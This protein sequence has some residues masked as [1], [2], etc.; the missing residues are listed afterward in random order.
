MKISSN[1]EE[2]DIKY[3]REAELQHSRIAMLSA[4]ILPFLDLQNNQLA[5]NVMSSQKASSQ[6]SWLVY[7]SFFEMARILSGYEN[8]F[9][10]GKMFKLKTDHTPGNLFGLQDISTELQEKELNNGRLAMLGT[11]G[12]M[13]QEL[14]TNHKI[15]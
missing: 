15:F 10:G 1:L 7:F 13:T 9:Q 12:Y 11:L 14:V 2:P 6:I 8:F 5:I 3:L 4:V